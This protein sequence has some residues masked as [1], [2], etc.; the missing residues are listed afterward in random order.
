MN[1]TTEELKII[2]EALGCL[3]NEVITED[4]STI[5]LYNKIEKRL[6]LPEDVHTIIE[7]LKRIGE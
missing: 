5:N 1:F 7:N 3:A 2:S 6:K 4:D